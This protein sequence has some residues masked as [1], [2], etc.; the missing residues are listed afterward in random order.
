MPFKI[1]V[2][3]CK[4]ILNKLVSINVIFLFVKMENQL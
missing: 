1:H 3:N 2:Y 4:N